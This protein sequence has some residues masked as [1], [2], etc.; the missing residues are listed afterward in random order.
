MSKRGARSNVPK[1]EGAILVK[2]SRT[3]TFVHRV[4]VRYVC[5]DCGTSYIKESERVAISI[6][7]KRQVVSV[8]GWFSC[9]GNK[10]MWTTDR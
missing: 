9:C 5:P 10:F 6:K 1:H 7:G 4:H 8:A 2:G 3:E